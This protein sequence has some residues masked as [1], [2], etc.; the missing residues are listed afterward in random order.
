MQPVNGLSLD[1]E[2]KEREELV[3]LRLEVQRAKDQ[4][5]R[6]MSTIE[7]EKGTL[8][9]QEA[10]L[11]HEINIVEE[12]VQKTLYNGEGVVI[13]LDRLKEKEKLRGGKEDRRRSELAILWITV[14]A[15]I[16]IEVFRLVTNT[17]TYFRN[18]I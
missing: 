9:R 3:R 8:Q 11:R 4:I 17:T 14:A 5:D 6:L 15:G 18:C 16:L 13:Q 10:R 12:K 2:N 1:M 7:S